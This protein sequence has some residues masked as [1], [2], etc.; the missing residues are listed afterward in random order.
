M[1]YLDNLQKIFWYSHFHPYNKFK[2]K[3]SV[4][5]IYFSFF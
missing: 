1:F 3:V 4:L 5:V 2:V